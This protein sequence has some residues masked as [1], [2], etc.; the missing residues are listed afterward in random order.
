MI[1]LIH[2]FDTETHVTSFES[3]DTFVNLIEW[4]DIIEGKSII[5]NTNGE[6]FKWDSSQQNEV[7]T[8]FG[9]S[10]LKTGETYAKMDRILIEESKAKFPQEF[11]FQK[12]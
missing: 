2:E 3:I 1:Y 8:V 4:Q 12:I 10:L 7:G 5:T 6:I 11:I 9:Y